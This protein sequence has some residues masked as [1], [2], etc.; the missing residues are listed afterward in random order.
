MGT[1]DIH[2]GATIAYRLRPAD[3]PRNPHKLWHGTVE[4]VRPP[5]CCVRLDEPLYEG[6]TEVIFL[7]QIVCIKRGK[8]RL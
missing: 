5:F 8:V 7:T 4:D 2:A 6:Q 3:R 1:E